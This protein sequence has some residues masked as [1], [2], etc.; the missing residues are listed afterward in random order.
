MS[1]INDAL[2]AMLF[3]PEQAS[4]FALKVDRLHF[5]VLV[6]TLLASSAIGLVAIAWMVRFRRRPGKA[7][8]EH[9]E[10]PA[11][12][13]V[14]I[15]AGPLSLF[16]L[17]F[18]IGFRDYVFL[19]SPPKGATDVYVTAKKW[20]WQFSYPGGP[21]SLEVLAVPAGRP[22]RLLLTSRD[23]IHSF[24]VPAFRIKQDALPG[25]YTQTWFL[26]NSPGRYEVLCAEYCGTAHSMMRGEVVVLKPEVF[27]AW[28]SE[29]KRG[30]VAR[31]DAGV[32]LAVPTLV[33]QGRAAAVRLGCLKC[34]SVDGTPHI[35]PTW[36]DLYQRTEDLE[37]G[38][39]VLADAGY[40]TESMMDPGAKLVRGYQNVM[41]TFQ[42][43]LAAPE[44]A[45]IVEYI[46]TL[47][48][49]AL[50]PPPAPGPIY[51]LRKR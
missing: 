17:W 36:L 24:F 2:R 22:V 45:S 38:G 43:L 6:T 41:P 26:S 3:L 42:G 30:L 37:G 20:M 46:E 29:Q 49:G 13:E 33:D 39:T 21:S 28:L 8:T 44:A 16:L 48:S 47:R 5:F 25:R 51:E 19:Q 18:G 12:M 10:P 4:T 1:F 9:Y 11:W 40:L 14:L 35:G 23:V 27:D 32:P 34:H 50:K 31:Q 7:T 15:V